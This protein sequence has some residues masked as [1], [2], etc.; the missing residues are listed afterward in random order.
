MHITKW[1]KSIWKNYTLSDS[2]YMTFWKIHWDCE[3]TE[4][5]KK[6]DQYLGEGPKG[7]QVS[8]KDF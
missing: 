3:T 2:N 1:N 5:G 7:E 4:L 6:K 8:T